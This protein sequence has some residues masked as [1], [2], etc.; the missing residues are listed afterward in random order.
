M[1]MNRSNSLTRYIPVSDWEKHHPWPPTGGLRHLI[2][3]REKNGFISVIKK[4]GKRV[5]IDESAF[6]T[7]MSTQGGNHESKD[8]FKK[9]QK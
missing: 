3:N 4:V 2:F 1:D 7:W 5:L 9:C 6:F 8:R